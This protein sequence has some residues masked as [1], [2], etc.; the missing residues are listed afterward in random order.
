MHPKSRNIEGEL[1]MKEVIELIV[2]EE[3]K[4]VLVRP[5][6]LLLD[7]L[8]DEILLTGTK[9]GCGEGDCGACTVLLDGSP[10][11]SC[12]TLAISCV[13]KKI[14][15]I[16]GL[17]ENGKLHPIQETFVEKGAIQCGYCTPGMILSA[18]A[19]LVKNPKPT[20]EEIKQGMAGNFCRCTGYKKIID[21]VSEAAGRLQQDER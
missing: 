11:L 3:P 5:N 14:E 7:V 17:S 8:R 18:K 16:E 9:K 4:E 13:G 1:G 6:D 12:L 21:A 19:L 20:H 10:A 2:N 15:T